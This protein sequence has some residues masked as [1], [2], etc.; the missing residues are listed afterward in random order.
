MKT[1]RDLLQRFEQL[2]AIG[3][4]LSSERNIDR[5]LEN[6]LLA[7]TLIVSVSSWRKVAKTDAAVNMVTA[8]ATNMAGRVTIH[9]DIELGGTNAR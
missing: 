1:A 6:I 5:L 4:A 2:N 7:A 3:A 9:V 8:L